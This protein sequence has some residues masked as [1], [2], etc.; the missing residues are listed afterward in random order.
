MYFSELESHNLILH[1]NFF[2]YDLN[3]AYL[4]IIQTLKSYYSLMNIYR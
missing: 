4:A 1:M 3:V 2:S